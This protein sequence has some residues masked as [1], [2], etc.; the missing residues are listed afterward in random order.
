MFNIF[1]F[2]KGIGKPAY[3]E[4]LSI[5]QLS[6]Q[7]QSIAHFEWQQRTLCARM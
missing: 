7:T 3:V 6:T 2:K 4:P 5:L 1:A